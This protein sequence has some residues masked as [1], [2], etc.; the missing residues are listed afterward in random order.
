MD[1]TFR[2][3][4]VP[5]NTQIATVLVDASS[6]ITAFNIDTTSVSVDGAGPVTTQ[7]VEATANHETSTAEIMKT[8]TAPTTTA[9]ATTKPATFICLIAVLFRV[10]TPPT[11]ALT[12]KVV[13]FRSTQDTFTPDLQ[14]SSSAAFMNRA[15]LIKRQIEPL[16]Q[17]QFPSSFNSLD[18]VSFRSGSIINTMNLRFVDTSVP[19]NNQIQNVLIGAASNVTDFDIESSSISVNSASSIT[20]T[21]KISLLTAA[22]LGLFPWLLT[23]Q[24][25]LL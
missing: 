22:S 24:Q 8:T 2:S 4:S 16:Y 14:N 21:H 13:T 3:T 19:D 12:T 11:V 10:T 20:A 7:A 9:A 25:L 5:N 17:R 15:S 6:N 18:L 1:L 23:S